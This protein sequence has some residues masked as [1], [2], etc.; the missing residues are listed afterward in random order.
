[1]NHAQS[2]KITVSIIITSNLSQYLMHIPNINTN[3]PNS[4]FKFFFLFDDFTDL[5]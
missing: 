4:S 3:Q 5:M 2:F 1:M